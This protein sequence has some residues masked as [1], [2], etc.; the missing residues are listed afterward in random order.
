ML[1]RI[2]FGRYENRKRGNDDEIE[3]ESERKGFEATTC[4]KVHVHKYITSEM[5]S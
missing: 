4:S 2:K 1:Q 5:M 3:K